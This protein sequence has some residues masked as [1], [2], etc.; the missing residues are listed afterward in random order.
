M[1]VGLRAFGTSDKG[2]DPHRLCPSALCLI[3]IS[4]DRAGCASSGSRPRAGRGVGLTR[5]PHP[6]QAALHC[7][8]CAP[9][10]FVLPGSCSVPFRP[11]P[12][13]LGLDSGGICL[14]TELPGSSGRGCAEHARS[15]GGGASARACACCGRVRAHRGAH[16]PLAAAAWDTCNVCACVCT[17]RC[18][19]VHMCVHPGVQG[20]ECVHVGVHVLVA[21]RALSPT[22]DLQS[23]GVWV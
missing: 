6:L 19:C 13:L 14:D 10:V 4:P 16:R 5:P 15:S 23:L 1:R 2:R 21:S 9:P 22:P 11:G 12:C 8:V 20:C 3:C 7:R 18:P 17:R